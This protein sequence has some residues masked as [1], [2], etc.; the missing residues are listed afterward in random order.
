MAV[1]RTWQTCSPIFKY[2]PELKVLFL[3]CFVFC[4]IKNY[5][6]LVFYFKLILELFYLISHHL[7]SGI[8]NTSIVLAEIRPIYLVYWSQVLATLHV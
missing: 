2:K 4:F 8:F 1:V 6:G 5:V 3:F 7:F